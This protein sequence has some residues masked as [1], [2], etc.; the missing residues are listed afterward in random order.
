MLRC[1]AI[2]LPLAALLSTV[3]GFG[4]IQGRSTRGVGLHRGDFTN[5]QYVVN[6]QTIAGLT[7]GQGM[8]IISDDSSPVEALK[9]ALETWN[10]VP[11]SQVHFAPLT[12]T[13]LD[14]PLADGTQLVTFADTPRTRAV[15]RGAIAVTLLFWNQDGELTDTDIVFN[16]ALD[17]STTLRPGT[18]DIQATMTHELGHAL[19]LDHSGIAGATMFALAARANDSLATLSS[20]DRAFVAATYPLPAAATTLGELTGR[21]TLPGGGGVRGAHV[22]GQSVSRN[23]VV[24]GITDAE[25]FYSIQGVPAGTYVIYVEPLD[26]PARRD[27]LGAAG[28]GLNSSFQTAF[29][30][31]DS[32]TPV[33]LL[34][35]STRETNFTVEAGS[36]ELNIEGAGAVPVGFEVVSR[37][38]VEIEPG[39]EYVVEVHGDALDDPSIT[40]TSLSFLGTGCT[41]VPGSFEHAGTVKFTNGDEFPVVRF[42]ITV[43]ANA[44]LGQASLRISSDTESSVYSGGFS[45][46]APVP[47]P[48][49]TAGAVVNAANFLPRG[50]SAGE[51]IS[52]FGIG[53]GPV[54]GLPGVL[55]PVTGML[56]TLV[57]DVSVTI[58]GIPL[59]LFFVRDDQ[60]NAMAPVEIADAG[61]VLLVVRYKQVSSGARI[62]PVLPT[63]PGLFVFPET[64]QAIV[65]NSDDTVNGPGNPA[66]RGSFISIFGTGQ[67]GIDPLLATG[68][69]ARG[70]ADLS[71]FEEATVVRIGG[72]ETIVLF[73]GMAPGFAGLFQINVFVP[74]GVAP[75]GAVLLELEV[76]GR[77]AQGGVTIAV[78]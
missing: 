22:V 73:T 27:Q 60:I 12:A 54:V 56:E 63:N 39:G 16:P 50:I 43:A 36:P 45:I 46:V 13:D 37:V 61:S 59:P 62:V 47:Q 58:D 11:A 75:G 76:G 18:F 51:I 26:G 68:E 9:A 5:V 74:A 72:I 19:G 20:D 42:Q 38:G 48:E 29:L 35:G 28:F 52:I 71:F 25:G 21:V 31:G 30:G 57:G 33:I 49:F 77:S 23:T 4:Y 70:G 32:P 2:Y 65:L 8:R 6:D 67:G 34:A 41:L 66:A 78:R 24:G 14:Q 7:N 55:N 53:L 10:A 15:V 3:S 64:T 1:R 17:Y 44:P 69:L 40:A